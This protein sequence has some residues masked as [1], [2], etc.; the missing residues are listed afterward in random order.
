MYGYK[1]INE[2]NGKIFYGRTDN[3]DNIEKH[4]TLLNEN[5]HWLKLLQKDFD[6]GDKISVEVI[7]EDNPK[8]VFDDISQRIINDKTFLAGIGYNLPFTYSKKDVLNIPDEDIIFFYLENNKKQTLSEYKIS[9]NVFLY[10]LKRNFLLKD[11]IK[12]STYDEFY[13][14]AELLLSLNG[15][16]LTASQILDKMIS[17]FIISSR[18][19]VTQ[20]KISKNL[21]HRKYINKKK[22]SGYLLYQI[23]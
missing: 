17:K 23:N 6:K 9:N 7:I 2:N 18:L 20:N 19:R 10:R 13:A 12:I 22:K 5:Q 14:Y 21:S 1:I 3:I 8:C 16:F 15:D 11:K 4:L